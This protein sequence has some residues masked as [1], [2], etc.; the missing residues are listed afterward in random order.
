MWEQLRRDD[1]WGC[2]DV[3]EDDMS[4]MGAMYAYELAVREL[5]GMV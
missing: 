1:F 4:A 5:E 2:W 3:N